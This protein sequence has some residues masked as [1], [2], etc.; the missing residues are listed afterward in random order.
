MR[1]GTDAVL[2]WVARND[3][4]CHWVHREMALKMP[5]CCEVTSKVSMGVPDCQH[6]H[7]VGSEHKLRSP[8]WWRTLSPTEPSGQGKLYEHTHSYL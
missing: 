4:S 5:D 6:L 8:A 2:S 1:K 7:L 3:T